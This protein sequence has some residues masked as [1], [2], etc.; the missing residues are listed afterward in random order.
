MKSNKYSGSVENIL[1]W[2]AMTTPEQR[3]AGF[4]WYQDALDWCLGVA[5]EYNVPLESVVGVVAAMSPNCAW[6]VNKTLAVK[7][8]SLYITGRRDW[9][10]W[11]CG[12]LQNVRVAFD[13]LESTTWDSL[14]GL[15]VNAFALAIL[16]G[17]HS[18]VVVVDR[19]AMRA[20]LDYPENLPKSGV[21]RSLFTRTAQAYQEAAEQVGEWA[22][23]VQAAVWV[24]IRGAAE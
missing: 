15:K 3:E 11:Q 13:I 16:A 19:W 5:G 14:S 18:D 6:S 23:Y 12:I 1:R 22:C 10:N 24:A 2:Y 7:I 21:N 4:K 9:E 8:I 17:G 20:Y